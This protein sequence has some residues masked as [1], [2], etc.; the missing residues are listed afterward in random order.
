MSRPRARVLERGPARARRAGFA[1]LVVDGRIAR[2]QGG[3]SPIVGGRARLEAR[4]HRRRRTASPDYS[5]LRQALDRGAVSDERDSASPDHAT[6][7]AAR[8]RSIATTPLN[9][10]TWRRLRGRCR[11]RSSDW[12]WCGVFRREGRSTTRAGLVTC[13]C[14]DLKAL[15]ADFAARCS[16]AIHF[17]AVR[18]PGLCLPG[19]ADIPRVRSGFAVVE[20]RSCFRDRQHVDGKMSCGRRRGAVAGAALAVPLNAPSGPWDGSHR[21]PLSS[22]APGR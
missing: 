9:A 18:S 19:R 5:R 21:F 10:P 14:G 2:R 17:D 20:V 11:R 8:G 13:R 6:S 3:R 15:Q 16:E 12:G 22:R 7:A 1:V 4:A